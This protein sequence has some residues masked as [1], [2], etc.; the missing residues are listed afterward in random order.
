[1][2]SRHAPLGGKTDGMGETLA[3]MSGCHSGLSRG[4]ILFG[5]FGFVDIARVFL[6]LLQ[7]SAD[8]FPCLAQAIRAI[9]HLVFYHSVQATEPVTRHGGEHMVLGVVIHMP[10]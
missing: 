2:C 7:D 8:M 1:M 3:F 4:R 5:H 6:L 9:G 10:I